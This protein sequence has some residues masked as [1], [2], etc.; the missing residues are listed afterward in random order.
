MHCRP[1]ACSSQPKASFSNADLVREALESGKDVYVEK[2]LCLCEAEGSSLVEFARQ[3]V[4]TNVV[5]P[6]VDVSRKDE[7]MDYGK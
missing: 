3:V 1:V 4:F 6:R 7:F 2:P 5:N